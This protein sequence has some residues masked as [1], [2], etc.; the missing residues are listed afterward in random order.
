MSTFGKRR[1]FGQHFLRDTSICDRIAHTAREL[2]QEYGCQALLEI[3]PGKGAITLPLI[4]AFDDLPTIR[5]VKL[6]EKDRVLAA[7][8]NARGKEMKLSKKF[9][10]EE[11]DFLELAEEGWLSTAPLAVVSNLPYSSGTAILTRLALYPKSI[12]FMVLMFQAEV[13]Q[14]L[15]AEPATKAWGS[16]SIWIQN[17]W[18]VSHLLR[19]PPSAFSPPPKVMSEVVV[20]KRRESLRI[21]YSNEEHFEKFLKTCFAHRRKMLKA[22]FRGVSE[23]YAKALALS[24]IDPTRRAETLDWKEWEKLYSAFRETGQPRI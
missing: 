14:R 21:P 17:R 18:D 1:A 9:S 23:N 13:A 15:R 2:A 24:G 4:D 10:V 16:L 7:N 11:A 19:V 6:V 12:P 5:E 22:T 3:G 20:L 8:W